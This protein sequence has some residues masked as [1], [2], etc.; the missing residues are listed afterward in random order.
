MSSVDRSRL[1]QPGAPRPFR[2]PSIGQHRLASGVDVRTVRHTAAPVVSLVALVRGGLA[3]DPADRLGLAAFTADL[4]DD[5]A[6]ALDGPG[7]GDAFARIGADVDIQVWPDATVL[8]ITTLARHVGRGVELLAD[9]VRRPHFLAD[10]VERVRALRLDRLR[11]M[12]AQAAAVA[13][14]AFMRAIYQSHPYGHFAIGDDAGVTAAA[15]DEI[16]AFHAAA[17]VPGATTIVVAGDVDPDAAQALVTGAFGDW[18]GPAAAGPDSPQ[19]AAPEPRR[20]VLI[21]PRPG[22]PQSELR[23]GQISAAR[24]TPDY[25]A[26]LLWNTVLGGQFVSRLNLNLRQSRGFTYGVRSGFDFRRDR[27]PFSIHTSV[28]TRVT[29][30]AIG[31]ILREVE[32]LSS[33]APVTTDELAR[34]KAAVG[35]GYPRG[36]E[37][38][39]QVARSVAAM[40]LHGLD[41][42]HFERFVPRLMAVTLDEVAAAAA[43]HVRADALTAV[44]VG[45]PQAVEPGLQDRGLAA[46]HLDAVA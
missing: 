44:V 6:G 31:E 26:L 16:R 41:P 2:F 7:L 23:V 28:Q 20:C 5:G 17:Y 36:F 33:I 30:D 35:L 8:S 1:P 27:G 10:D 42:D 4:L 12:R 46:E 38:A 39:Q 24:R 14:R 22:A 34:A 29:G 11:Q 13:D 32:E 18:S 9:L 25:H 19:G 43:R 21:V 40:A 3:A 37:T 15:G 45:D